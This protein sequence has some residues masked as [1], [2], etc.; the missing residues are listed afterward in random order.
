[1]NRKEI[2][3]EPSLYD[4]LYYELTGSYLP[5]EGAAYEKLSTA[6]IGILQKKGVSHDMRIRGKSGSIYQIDGLVEEIIMVEAKDYAK[7]NGKVPRSDLQKQEGALI[8]LSNIEEGYFASPTGYTRP[9]RQYAEGTK[10]NDNAKK[11]TPFDIRKSTDEDEKGRIKAFDITMDTICIEYRQEDFHIIWYDDSVLSSFQQALQA[12]GQNEIKM[13]IGQ[14]YDDN[15]VPSITMEEVTRSQQPPV[16]DGDKVIKG[17]FHV[18]ANIKQFDK[19][20][21]IKGIGYTADVIHHIRKFE[22]K[23]KGENI[24]LAKCDELGIDTLLTDQEIKDA[25]KRL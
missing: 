14:F 2:N 18:D 17:M 16:Q 19:L 10:S 9:A 25:L 4:D 11:I 23:K 6:I 5:K 1:M 8:D 24:M 3:Y 20:F 21:K 7:R 13:T 22:V 15:G 12:F